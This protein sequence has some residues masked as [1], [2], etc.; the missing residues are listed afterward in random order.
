MVS[1]YRINSTDLEYVVWILLLSWKQNLRCLGELEHTWELVSGPILESLSNSVVIWQLFLF[2][3]PLVL[4]SVYL[5]ALFSPAHPETWQLQH[6]LKAINSSGT[7]TLRLSMKTHS[8]LTSLTEIAIYFCQTIH[9][10]LCRNRCS[11]MSTYLQLSAD[12]FESS[13]L[14]QSY[15]LEEG[16]SLKEKCLAN[17]RNSWNVF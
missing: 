15:G 13:E 5:S 2:C 11:L 14:L 4:I 12:N 16:C 1:D 7:F 8:K 6:Y 17:S 9:R 3:C 10:S